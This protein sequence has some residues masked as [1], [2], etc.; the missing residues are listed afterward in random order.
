[1]REN[2]IEKSLIQSKANTSDE[3]EPAVTVRNKTDEKSEEKPEISNHVME[4]SDDSN[5]SKNNQTSPRLNRLVQ[6]FLDSK[7]AQLN[8]KH[9]VTTI[10]EEQST[11]PNGDSSETVKPSTPSVDSPQML[12][13]IDTVQKSFFGRHPDG[14]DVNM[15][16]PVLSVAAHYAPKISYGEGLQMFTDT[17]KK[18]LTMRQ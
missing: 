18:S 7:Q 11:A 16:E 12:K 9:N 14:E 3:V 4:V 1:M 17:N 8:A 6:F 5:N 15:G 13:S 2:R 10:A